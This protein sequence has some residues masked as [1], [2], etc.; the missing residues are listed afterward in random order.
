MFKNSQAQ[1]FSKNSMAHIS[2]SR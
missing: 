1:I 2:A